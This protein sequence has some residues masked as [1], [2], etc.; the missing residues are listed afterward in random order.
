MKLRADNTEPQAGPPERPDSIPDQATGLPWFD[1]WRGVY[2]FVF[3]SFVIWVG[4][5]LALTVAFS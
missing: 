3:M 2:V 4:L 1:T 5:L